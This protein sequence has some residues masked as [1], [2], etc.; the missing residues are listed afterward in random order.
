MPALGSQAKGS[1]VR[2]CPAQGGAGTCSPGLPKID[3]LCRGSMLTHASKICTGNKMQLSGLSDHLFMNNDLC[4][5]CYSQC[6]S[7]HFPLRLSQQTTIHNL[8]RR[9]S[10][11]LWSP[12]TQRA[13]VTQNNPEI[14]ARPEENEEAPARA[15]TGG[16]VGP[17]GTSP[18]HPWSLHGRPPAVRPRDL[19][20]PPTFATLAAAQKSGHL[21]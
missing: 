14:H 10:K 1:T 4:A 9:G 7:I 8:G 6:L 20:S 16:A 2:G 5:M 19:F 3:Y 12:A 15:A 21:S 11:P 17:T 13:E 18:P